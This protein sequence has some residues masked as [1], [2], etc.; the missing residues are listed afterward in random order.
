MSTFL[1]TRHW[2]YFRQLLLAGTMLA[3]IGRLI[4]IVATLAV[5][6]SAI[7]VEVTM[8]QAQTAARNW[9]RRSPVQMTAEFKSS[10]VRHAQT[11][12]ADDGKAL[13]HVVE[14]DGG[15]FVVTSGD[16]ELPPVIAFSASGTLDLSD[17]R[18][19][20][21]ALLE[22]DLQSRRAQIA[23]PQAKMLAALQAAGE[24][25]PA[26]NGSTVADSGED[27]NDEWAGLLAEPEPVPKSKGSMTLLTSSSSISDVRVAPIVQSKWDQSTWNGYNTFNYY[28]PNNYVCG[29]V[30]TAFA[31]IM[32]YWRA[33]SSSISAGTYTCWVDLKKTSKTML[34]G[35]YDWSSMPLTEANCSSSSQRQAI[36]KLTYDVGVAS[37][38][39]WTSGESGTLGCVAAQ[40]LRHRF[41][42]ASAHS[43]HNEDA[44]LESNLSLNADYRNAIL[45]SL[46]AGM[47]VA[48]GIYGNGGHEVVVDGYGYNGSSTIYCHVN[49]GWSG[50]QDLWYNLMGE[51]VTSHGFSWMADVSYNIHP[52]A[53]GDVISGRVLNASGSPVSGA[54]VTLTTAFGSQLTT[55]TNAKGIYSFRAAANASYTV[56][57][58]YGGSSSV[59]QSVTL[60][61]SYDTEVAIAEV[62]SNGRL[63]I[64][65]LTSSLYPYGK[66]GN[67][68]G[69]NLTLGSYVPPSSVSLETALDNTSLAF[70]T[71]GAAS[72]YGQTAV[73]YDGIDAAR[74]GAIGSSQQTWLETT[75]TGPGTLS[76]YWNVS[77][78]GDSSNR[79]W[80]YLNVSI[81]GEEKARICGTDN[82]WTRQ[83][84]SIPTGTHTVRWQ[85]NKDGS[86]SKGDDAAYVDQIVWTPT[87]ITDDAYDPGDD[88]PSG[89]TVITPSGSLAIHYGHTLSSTDKYDFFKIYLSAGYRYVFETTGDMDTYGDLFDSTTLA[90]SVACNDDSGNNRNFKIEYAPDSSG[91][92]YLRVRAY[93][94]GTAGS[95]ALTYQRFATDSGGS[96]VKPD[97][98]PYT[99]SDWSSPLVVSTSNLS[100]EGAT[101]FSKNDTLYVS[102]AGVCRNADITSTFY[103]RLYIDGSL[104][105]SWRTDGLPK[106][107]YAWIGG[108][109]IGNL[110]PGKHVIRIVLDQTDVVVESNESNNTVETE[111]TVNA[112]DL[113]NLQVV[114]ANLSKNSITLSETMTVHWRVANPG[115]AAV[116]KTKTAFEIWKYDS[117]GDTWA[118]KRTDWLDCN[119]LA[120]GAGK[121]YA[122]SITGKSLG[123]GKFVI[124]VRVDGKAAISES[125]E[126]DNYADTYAV[127]VS[128]DN[129]TR[130]TSGVDWQFHKMKG[131]PDS[132]YL[133]TSAKAKKKATTFRVGQP[134]YM[135]CCWWNATR[136]ATSGHM[137]MRVSLNGGGGVYSEH[138]YTLK[139]YYYYLVNR[140]PSFLQNL[141]AGKYTLTATLDSENNW[142]EKNE[143]NNIRRISFTVVG[144]PTIYS[145]AT[146]TCALNEPVNWAI[147]SEGSMTVKGLPKGMK[148]SGGVISG[149]ASKTGTY[150][151]D[152]RREPRLRCQRECARQRRDRRC[153]R[154]GGRDGPDVCRCGAEHFRRFYAGQGWDCKIGG[155]VSDG[156]RASSRT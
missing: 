2:G 95:Y 48:V 81:D 93:K 16:T 9:V 49:C 39:G 8:E 146:Y 26:T 73:S 19:P 154:C 62:Y 32:R 103:S 60:P 64:S 148:Y 34:G 145:E 56:S 80:D 54:T 102:W 66:L 119:P 78:E 156:G 63:S 109:Q 143:K 117:S 141:P 107:Y 27:F 130:S 92:Y 123:V 52:T 90:N 72:W 68:W 137:R 44:T 59:E 41:G 70:T 138:W 100:K 14:L 79:N 133:S 151:Q 105:H 29:C 28:T 98:L 136:R 147:S 76:F 144:A 47:P 94:L 140:T 85:Y 108:H 125:D 71:G 134:I 51:S 139:N 127:T 150:T 57:A 58:S 21:V 88:T 38:M 30:A 45:A 152:C 131:E 31:Q 99:P 37:Q 46:D 43:Y 121:E 104:V 91:T 11:A 18:N 118:L 96:A 22:R 40:A 3:S 142:R 124:R 74:S 97:L 126:S 111:V 149:K 5:V 115:K 69:V 84:Y 87:A 61:S 25:V 24:D 114:K 12:K 135:R 110:N 106:N 20:L 55:T 83:S 36:G 35:S 82:S 129:A 128:K 67:K 1:K 15:G 112:S 65:H 153:L 116:N 122:R 101:S 13:Y 6:S 4:A 155:V 132:F 120:A 77:C 50:S 10:E 89:G 7:A 42:Y 53:T 23:K 33:P 86:M 17:S 75:V 113:P